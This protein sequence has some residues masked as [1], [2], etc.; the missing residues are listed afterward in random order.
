MAYVQTSEQGWK[1]DHL[2]KSGEAGVS[3]GAR[4]VGMGGEGLY[5]RPLLLNGVARR[6]FLRLSTTMKSPMP[7]DAGDHKGPPIH[8]S[9]T[10][11]PTDVTEP[12]G[13]ALLTR[14]S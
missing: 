6:P 13:P 8:P 4:V 3:V 7:G 9:S 1:A 5:G 12:K 10:L 14:P 11:A 2:D